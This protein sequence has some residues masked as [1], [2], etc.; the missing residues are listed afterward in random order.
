M[1]FIS[2]ISLF[3]GKYGQIANEEVVLLVY[4]FQINNE[5]FLKDEMI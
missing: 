1:F 2:E 3:L 4:T 5:H